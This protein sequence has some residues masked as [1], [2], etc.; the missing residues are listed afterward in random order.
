MSALEEA[1]AE[2]ERARILF[3]R[4]LSLPRIVEWSQLSE[5]NRDQ[6]EEI[7]NRRFV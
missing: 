6:I 1:L 5:E 2:L 7:A 3:P 4:L